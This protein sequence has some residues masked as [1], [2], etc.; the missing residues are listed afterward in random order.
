MSNGTVNK[1]LKKAVNGKIGEMPRF[2]KI[3]I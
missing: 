2:F 3:E 1:F